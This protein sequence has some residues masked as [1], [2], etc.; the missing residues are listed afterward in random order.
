M[1]FGIELFLALLSGMHSARSSGRPVTKPAAI[2]VGIINHSCSCLGLEFDTA[3]GTAGLWCDL[4]V[5]STSDSQFSSLKGVVRPGATQKK[6]ASV[7]SLL[8]PQDVSISVITISH[9]LGAAEVLRGLLR[10]ILEKEH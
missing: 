8:E 3:S 4:V 6:L 1:L 5:G 10:P 9:K 7:L 2:N